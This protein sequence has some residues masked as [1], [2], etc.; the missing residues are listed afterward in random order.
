VVVNGGSTVK[1]SN[2]MTTELF[3]YHWRKKSLG[4]GNNLGRVDAE[5]EPNEGLDQKRAKPLSWPSG[6]QRVV[7]KNE[8]DRPCSCR[9]A[10]GICKAC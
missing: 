3:R 8:V 6:C 4:L 1:Y 7:S 5:R 9:F 2:L 10:I